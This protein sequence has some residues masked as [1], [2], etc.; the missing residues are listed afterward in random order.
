VLG[1][2][3][4]RVDGVRAAGARVRGWHADVTVRTDLRDT[5]VLRERVRAAAEQEIARLAP[6][7]PMSLRVRVHGPT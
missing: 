1:G 7:H 5:A 4:G 2:A 6:A 3:A